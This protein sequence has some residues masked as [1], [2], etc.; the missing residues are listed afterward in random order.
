ML[1]I[2]RFPAHYPTAGLGGEYSTQCNMY[3]VVF[4]KA[5]AVLRDHSP[6]EE[7]ALEISK[8]LDY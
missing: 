4:I 8:D 6:Y 5:Q 2:V 1:Q 3:A 7:S